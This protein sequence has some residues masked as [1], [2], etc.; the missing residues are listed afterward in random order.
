LVRLATGNWQPATE[1]GIKVSDPKDPRFRR[2]APRDPFATYDKNFKQENQ[3]PYTVFGASRVAGAED[4][5]K[6]EEQSNAMPVG[7][8]LPPHLFIPAD[9]Q[10]V[11]IR[12]LAN[13]PPATTVVLMSFKGLNGGFTNF[14]SYGVFF[15]ALM[16][17]L[18]NLVPLVNGSRVFPLHG[19]PNRN[20]KIGLG[21][22]AD[23]SNANLIPCQLVL[24]PGDLLEWVF[25]NND[26]VDVAAG[27]RMSGYFD[28]STTRRTLRFGG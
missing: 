14:I 4:I 22:G 27:V 24:Q 1:G 23:L 7:V 2:D 8:S 25:T 16:F 12:T 10:S 20:F 28:Q 3:T 18:I 9:A 11:D 17:D 26:I 5:A 6:R 15:D 21:T 13:V 19:N